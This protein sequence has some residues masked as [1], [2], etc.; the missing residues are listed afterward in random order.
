MEPIL[1]KE[2]VTPISA[3]IETKT[4]TKDKLVRSVCKPKI[5]ET[6]HAPIVKLEVNSD[7]GIADSEFSEF[8]KD[9]LGKRSTHQ[10]A[11]IELLIFQAM[12]WA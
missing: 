5:Q 3:V 12:D 4:P 10:E 9:Q 7:W 8:N 11:W 1:P 6:F 2:E